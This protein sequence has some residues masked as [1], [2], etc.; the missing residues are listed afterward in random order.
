MEYMLLAHLTAKIEYLHI[1]LDGQT[2]T[3]GSPPPSSPGV[4]MNYHFNSEQIDLIR[5]GLSYKF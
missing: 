5:G 3:L 1:G 4:F 2:V